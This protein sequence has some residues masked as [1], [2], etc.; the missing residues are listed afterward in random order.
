M[1]EVDPIDGGGGGFWPGIRTQR[2]DQQGG[3]GLS[4]NEVQLAHK[5]ADRLS[6]DFSDIGSDQLAQCA[7]GA[8]EGSCGWA[9]PNRPHSPGAPALKLV[10]PLAPRAD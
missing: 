8:Q 6:I 7:N 5:K 4:R 10:E 1:Q 9:I 2:L 3:R